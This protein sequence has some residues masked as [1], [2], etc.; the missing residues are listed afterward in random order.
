MKSI[1]KYVFPLAGLVVLVGCGRS[2]ESSV[3]HFY[4]SLSEGKISDAKE[5]V[6]KQLLGMA[7]EGKIQSALASEA[8]KIQSRGGIKS[9]QVHLEGKG[10][11]RTGTVTITYNK[12]AEPKIEKVKVV[13]EDGQWKLAAEK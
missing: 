11:I 8:Q 5:L 9:M 3:E 2:A 13:K 12:V 10:E 6:S 1:C 4:T 7:G